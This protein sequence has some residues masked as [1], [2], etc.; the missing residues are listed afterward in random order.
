MF[1]MLVHITGFFTSELLNACAN[2]A[3]AVTCE[4][5][6]GSS[7]HL[8]L[9]LT[10]THVTVRLSSD[11]NTSDSQLHTTQLKQDAVARQLC[12]P[13]GF[14]KLSCNTSLHGPRFLPAHMPEMRDVQV[15]LHWQVQHLCMPCYKRALLTVTSSSRQCWMATECQST[16]T[17]SCSPSQTIRYSVTPQ[18]AFGMC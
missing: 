6:S 7:V 10:A 14:A 2:M 1:T 9:H 13:G 3:H 17:G 16:S 15:I 12:E 11:I 8:C 18:H 5:L 4:P